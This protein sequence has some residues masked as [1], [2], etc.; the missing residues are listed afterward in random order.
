MTND[1]L[2]EKLHQMTDKS[3]QVNHISAI[4]VPHIFPNF[5]F[6][7]SENSIHFGEKEEENFLFN[8]Y[9]EIISDPTDDHDIL[10]FKLLDNGMT[11]YI[12]VTEL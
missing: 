11:A 2:F 9:K 5:E 7:I 4:L 3:V 6:V 1:V 10:R 12:E 8:I